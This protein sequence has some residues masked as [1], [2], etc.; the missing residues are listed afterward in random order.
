[1]PEQLHQG[2]PYSALQI[3]F[4]TYDLL[5]V[6]HTCSCRFVYSAM[7]QFLIQRGVE[8]EEDRVA[9][10]SPDNCSTQGEASTSKIIKVISRGHA[11]GYNSEREEEFPWL[12]RLK[13]DSGIVTGMLNGICKMHKT[14]NKYNKSRVWSGTPCTCIRKDSVRRHSQFLQHKDGVEKELAREQS[15]CDGGLQQA[16]QTQLSFNKAAVKTAMQCLYW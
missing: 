6:Y 13:N 8:Q 11:V 7:K 5:Q 16:F 4:L 10:D 14:D 3:A 12:L 2:C 15:S 9:E 1:M